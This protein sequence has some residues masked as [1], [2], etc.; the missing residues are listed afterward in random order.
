MVG[1]AEIEGNAAHEQADD[2]KPAEPRGDVE[3]RPRVHARREGIEARLEEQ[4]DGVRSPGQGGLG[5]SP[6]ILGVERRFPVEQPA[7]RRLVPPPG[8]GGGEVPARAPALEER[9]DLGIP[10]SAATSWGVWP[11]P[12]TVDVDVATPRKP[13]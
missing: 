12:Q 6:R 5:K 1:V 3:A 9:P 11:A 2:G 10:R 4:A 8:G 7:D 13:S